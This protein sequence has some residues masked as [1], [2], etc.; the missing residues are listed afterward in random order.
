MLLN[1]IRALNV[2]RIDAWNVLGFVSVLP[3]FPYIEIQNNDREA[4]ARDP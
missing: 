3:S 1:L 2:A 4:I